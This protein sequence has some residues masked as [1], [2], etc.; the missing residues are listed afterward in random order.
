MRIR[1]AIGREI[2]NEANSNTE[3]HGAHSIITTSSQSL[4]SSASGI[5]N[6]ANEIQS[7]S[8]KMI[9]VYSSFFLLFML[10]YSFYIFTT[11]HLL[12]I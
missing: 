3:Y 1:D 6:E 5:S 10:I 11:K 8:G 12:L 2:I 4:T 9:P 7:N